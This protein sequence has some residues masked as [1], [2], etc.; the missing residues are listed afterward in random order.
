MFS[1]AIKETQVSNGL[2]HKYQVLC[3]Q[4]RFKGWDIWNVEN[5]Q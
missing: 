5:Y 1:G 3:G 2:I 4:E